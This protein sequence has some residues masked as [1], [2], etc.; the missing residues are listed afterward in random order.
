[1]SWGYKGSGSG[2]EDVKEGWWVGG[3]DVK[4]MWWVGDIEEVE[5][6]G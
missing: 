1:M 3:E 5:A 6:M 2:G 4:E